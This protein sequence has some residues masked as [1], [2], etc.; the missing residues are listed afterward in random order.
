MLRVQ[1][2]G[3]QRGPQDIP[4]PAGA[5]EGLGAEGGHTEIGL[6]AEMLQPKEE[7]LSGS[8]DFTHTQ[9]W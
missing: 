8:L 6:E 5:G 4:S 9:G 7:L 3:G 2:Q 1:A